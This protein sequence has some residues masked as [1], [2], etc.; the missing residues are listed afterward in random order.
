VWQALFFLSVFSSKR[1]LPSVALLG[2]VA[3]LTYFWA[4]R[5][6]GPFAA[7][8][9]VGPAL[10]RASGSVA[11]SSV[12]V[13]EQPL[14]FPYLPGE[15]RDLSRSI[16][17]TSDGR[18]VQ[19][20]AIIESEALAILPIQRKRDLAYGT[21]E[22][23]ELIRHA[24]R[25]LYKETKTRLWV[26]NVGRKHGGDIRYSVSHNS[27]RDADIAFCYQDGK[28]RPVDPPGLIPIAGS[29]RAVGRPLFFDVKRTWIVVKAL[30]SHPDIQVQYL[31][32][33][34][35]LREKLMMQA[36]RL[37]E[38][39]S[40]IDRAMVTL[41]QPYGSAAH[42]DHLHLRIYC[43]KRDVV[44][45]CKNT[46]VKHSWAKMHET[47]RQRF[48]ER[49]AQHLQAETATVRRQAIE[50]LTL[51]GAQ[52]QTKAVAERLNDEASE[53]RE[54]VAVALARLAGPA[55]LDALTN[56][57]AVETTPEVRVAIVHT[58]SDIGG[59]TAGEF[60]AQAVGTA[61]SEKTSI[62]P[63]LSPLPL[64]VLLA[65]FPP[66]TERGQ[67][68]EPGARVVQLAAIEAAG[69]SERLEP[70]APL[71]ALLDDDSG[72]VRAAAAHA[73][74]KL[75]N[76][77]YG[78]NWRRASSAKMERGR[79]RWHA[80]LSRS[81]NAPREAWL[82][83][84]WRAAGFRVRALEPQF[85]WELARA[86][87]GHDRLSYNA[88]RSLMRMFKHRPKSLA[89][90]KHDACAYWQ[91]WLKRRRRRLALPPVPKNLSCG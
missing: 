17:D 56:R 72:V 87:G 11:I 32:A 65:R 42:N 86:V 45:G 8:P 48:A 40:L 22:I 7:E 9:F 28:S 57:F 85:A 79:A 73:L 91:R 31:F 74:R 23:V 47:T 19:A 20:A 71:I 64:A 43:S 59:E 34:Q 67:A 60:L 4:A 12:T 38:P 1:L 15:A 21:T 5:W 62:P 25:A 33:S 3:V 2:F 90:P 44:S 24:A 51:L 81:R 14:P 68:Q 69:R 63:A 75:T 37:R 80:A 61:R 52:S 53:V 46:G 18:L 39:A 77:S 50:R 35:S 27:G 70:V 36:R 16:G 49:S 78:V 30:L 55:Q 83:T 6:H 76:L 66:L 13:P 29:G 10:P 41:R 89:W 58:V 54:A 88:Q 82:T 84:G 26:G